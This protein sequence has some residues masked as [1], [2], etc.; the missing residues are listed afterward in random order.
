LTSLFSSPF[1]I[2]LF[3]ALF[4]AVMGIMDGSGWFSA[5]EIPIEDTSLTSAEIAKMKSVTGSDT[6]DIGGM[7]AMTTGAWNM[8]IILLTAM[9]RVV[10]IYDI[11]LDIFVPGAAPGSVQYVQV[12]AVAGLV[13][14][15]IWLIYAVG[16]AQMLSKSSIQH[17][18]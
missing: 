17:Y 12:A 14:I 10:W 13:Q 7:V 11:I 8:I 4:G 5:S 1:D 16:I 9:A 18:Q 6:G 2:A 3:L 15:G